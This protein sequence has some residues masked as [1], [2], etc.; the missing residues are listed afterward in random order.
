MAIVIPV[1]CG[2]RTSLEAETTLLAHHFVLDLIANHVEAHEGRWPENW[3]QLEQVRPT[4]QA[5]TWDWPADRG[6]I[7]D[8]VNVDFSLRSEVVAGM[9]SDSFSAVTPKGLH[10]PPSEARIEQFLETVRSALEASTISPLNE[11]Q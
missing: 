10:F 1:V 6:Q 8:R 2:V 3:Q 9:T 11:K 5:L 4:R 7:E